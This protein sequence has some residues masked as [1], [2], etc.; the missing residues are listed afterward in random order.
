MPAPQQPGQRPARPA[1]AE[2]A[3]VTRQ[4]GVHPVEDDREASDAEAKAA[5]GRVPGDGLEALLL[6]PLDPAVDG[7]GATVADGADVLP[8]VAV[9]QEQED[10]A[11]GSDVGIGVMTISVEQHPSLPGVEGHAMGHGCESRV[12]RGG[13][14]TQWY[15]PRLLSPL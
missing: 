9:G 7:A 1:V 3:E 6:E 14:S 2:E 15:R 4:L 10:V 12:K 5:A 11:T 8:G 13:R